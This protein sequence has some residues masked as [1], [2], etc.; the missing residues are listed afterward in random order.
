MLQ[1]TSMKRKVLDAKAPTIEGVVKIVFKLSGE[2][3]KDSTCKA[4]IRRFLSTLK[5]LNEWRI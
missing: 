5:G 2:A 3:V 4:L 1:K